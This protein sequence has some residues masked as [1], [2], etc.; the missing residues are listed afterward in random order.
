M[1]HL[2]DRTFKFSVASKAVGFEI[3]N[4]GRV[5]EN[6]FELVF[7]LWG[8]GGPNWM[9][10]EQLFYC[11]EDAS[12]TLVTSGPRARSAPAA[13]ASG[14]QLRPSIFSLLA[15][16]PSSSNNVVLD[17]NES[18]MQNL[19]TSGEAHT[20]ASQGGNQGFSN[21][22][23]QCYACGQLGHFARECP[24]QR[25]PRIFPFL[26]FPSFASPPNEAWNPDAV[27]D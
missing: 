2:K 26:R 21:I 1:L 14:D 13:N 15:N 3:Y 18:L 22:S 5:V 16:I 27:Q 9:R 4:H 10:E 24:E 17:N 12:W 19:N 25:L 6:D 20:K 23:L 7:N 8:F 11:E